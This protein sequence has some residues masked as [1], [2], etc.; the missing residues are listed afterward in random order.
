MPRSTSTARPPTP[1]RT[2]APAAR[3]RRR[4]APPARTGSARAPPPRRLGAPAPRRND[5]TA[6]LPPR[7]HGLRRHLA[8][9]RP[10]ARARAWRLA[11]RAL[12]RERQRLAP[13]QALED[14]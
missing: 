13:D 2:G 5:A 4:P 14:P 9:R 8:P 1:R 11:L 3:R 7:P 10:R 12:G 6:R